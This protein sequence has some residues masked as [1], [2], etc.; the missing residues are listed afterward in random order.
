MAGLYFLNE[1]LHEFW[2]SRFSI[3]WSNWSHMS[4]WYW[5]YLHPSPVPGM[6]DWKEPM[7]AEG[8]QT[9]RTPEAPRQRRRQ[10]QSLHIFESYELQEDFTKSNRGFNW[11]VEDGVG[12]T[13]FPWHSCWVEKEG[14][15]FAALVLNLVEIVLWEGKMIYLFWWRYVLFMEKKKRLKFKSY[16]EIQMFFTK[17]GF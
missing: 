3:I 14:E 11:G 9:I 6:T 2:Q 8:A 16:C 5:C 15:C 1:L 7:G 13:Y 12:K 10:Y 17:C 4:L